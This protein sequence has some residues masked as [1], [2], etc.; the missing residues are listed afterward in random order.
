MVQAR[1]R[2]APPLLL[3]AG[4]LVLAFAGCLASSPSAPTGGSS[5]ETPAQ[6]GPSPV[7]DHSGERPH[8]HDRWGSAERLVLFDDTVQV[9]DHQDET[10]T[11]RSAWEYLNCQFYCN[12]YASMRLPLDVIVPPGTDHLTITAEWDEPDARMDNDSG[13]ML[14][15]QP[16]NKHFLLDSSWEQPTANWT[17]NTSVEMADDGHAR[18][19]LWRFRFYPCRC[20]TFPDE[21][22]EFDID[23]RV[24]AHRVEG[25]LPLDPPHPDWWGNGTTRPVFSEEGQLREF[26][27]GENWVRPTE[28]G[29]GIAGFHLERVN[30]TS[31]G[32][33]PPGSQVLTAWMNWTDGN[34]TD[35][36]QPVPRI[37]W[38]NS[39]RWNRWEAASR[40]AGSY[41]FV[42]PLTDAM[43]DGMYGERSRW[44]FRYGFTGQDANTPDPVFGGSFTR[45]YYID[46]EWS[47]EVQVSGEPLDP[48]S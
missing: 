19:S 16:A 24:V 20:W 25:E 22:W 5:N 9:Q 14:S 12:P 43:V 46:G 17:I 3:A 2:G 7:T 36:A 37:D 32:G 6:E 28:P 18:F 8:V 11:S 21:R 13:A 30:R 1:N 4:L 10:N 29:V 38:S 34:P 15:Y 39:D 35:S 33:V 47:I 27:Y 26:G 31:H 40:D 48:S 23:V 42:L 44:E 45:P 41:K